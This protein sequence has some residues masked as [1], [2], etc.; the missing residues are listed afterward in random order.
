MQNR[1][2]N[3]THAMFLRILNISWEC[4]VVYCR[5]CVWPADAQTLIPSLNPFET[6]NGRTHQ[7]FLCQ[8]K[9]F[10]SELFRLNFHL[11][12]SPFWFSI[13]FDH[14]APLSFK[15]LSSHL[16]VPCKHCGFHPF[17]AFE[18]LSKFSFLS[19]MSIHR[20]FIFCGGNSADNV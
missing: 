19:I 3:G 11:R 6:L 13:T 18:F 15:A 17:C 7:L 16:A 2:G 20:S 14:S 4:L 12:V 5:R 1:I 9:I 10:R 8:L